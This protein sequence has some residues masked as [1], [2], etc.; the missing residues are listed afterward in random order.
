MGEVLEEYILL[1]HHPSADDLS[2]IAEAYNIDVAAV[3][4]TIR[5]FFPDVPLPEV[6]DELLA[7][8]RNAI[9]YRRRMAGETP[10]PLAAEYGISP[11]RIDQIVKRQREFEEARQ[12]RIESYRRD[13]AE[14]EELLRAEEAKL[15]RNRI[16]ED[17]DGLPRNALHKERGQS[18]DLLG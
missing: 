8:G 17:P 9:I 2:W 4:D 13:L 3:R 18:A 1:G 5:L 15:W 16:R 11:Q 7:D 6:S 10:T 14:A 12:S